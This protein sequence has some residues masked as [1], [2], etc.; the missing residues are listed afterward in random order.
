MRLLDDGVAVP[1]LLEPA[2]GPL[3]PA[4]LLLKLSGEAL[5]DVALAFGSWP[6]GPSALPG[7]LSLAILA[8][9]R[10]LEGNGRAPFQARIQFQEDLEILGKIENESLF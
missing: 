4:L 7:R 3:P 9:R 8:L 6:I 10:I 5:L 2:F 1:E